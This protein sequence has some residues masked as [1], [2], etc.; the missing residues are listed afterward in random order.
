MLLTAKLNAY[1]FRIKALRSM[2]NPKRI[3]KKSNKSY[4]TF[5]KTWKEFQNASRF[6]V[7]TYFLSTS[8]L[9]LFLNETDYANYADDSTLYKACEN[10]DVDPI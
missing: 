3:I 4:K 2:N 10:F 1:W 9:F 8:D 6:G 5:N 7:K